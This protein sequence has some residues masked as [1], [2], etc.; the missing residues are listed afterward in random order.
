[1]KAEAVAMASRAP[2]SNPTLRVAEALFLIA[3]SP[4]YAAI[5]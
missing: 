5:R 3:S 1:V 2:L 4:E